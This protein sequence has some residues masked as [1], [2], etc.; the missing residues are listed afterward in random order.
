MSI[1][2]LMLDDDNH[3]PSYHAED[4]SHWHDANHFIKYLTRPHTVII[5]YEVRKVA[6]IDL[7]ID[8]SETDP[9]IDIEHIFDIVYFNGRGHSLEE[10]QEAFDILW[11][12]SEEI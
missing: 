8:F 5:P 7:D 3:T 11:K 10:Y 1:R 12:Y 4:T 9:D 2:V 6:L